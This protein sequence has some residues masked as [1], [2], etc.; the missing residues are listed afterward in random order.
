[1]NPLDELRAMPAEGM[2]F[3][4]RCGEGKFQQLKADPRISGTTASLLARGSF[5]GI[6]TWIANKSWIE[7]W[8][9]C[10]TWTTTAHMASPSKNSDHSATCQSAPSLCCYRWMM[11]LV[12]VFSPVDHVTKF[13]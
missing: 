12:V 3:Y 4:T 1:M 2:K 5:T 8:R 7:C 9:Y 13:S 10:S 11:P 6:P